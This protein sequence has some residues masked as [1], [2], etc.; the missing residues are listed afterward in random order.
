MLCL[1]HTLNMFH[2]KVTRRQID[3]CN[4]VSK[5]YCLIYTDHGY[6]ADLIRVQS[7]KQTVY[8][9]LYKYMGKYVHVLT[10]VPFHDGKILTP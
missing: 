8:L 9:F 2:L 3:R 5:Q 6:I 4:L 7:E 10:G 1:W